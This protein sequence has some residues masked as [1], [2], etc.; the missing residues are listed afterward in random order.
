MSPSGKSPSRPEPSSTARGG[1][2]SAKSGIWIGLNQFS[3]DPRLHRRVGRHPMPPNPS[4]RQA[5]IPGGSARKAMGERRFPSSLPWRPSTGIPGRDESPRGRPLR[6]HRLQPA[7]P[8]VHPTVD[9]DHRTGVGGILIDSD[10]STQVI[11]EP[12]GEWF[13]LGP[14]CRQTGRCAWSGFRAS[15]RFRSCGEWSTDSHL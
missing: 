3:K 2:V 4:P 5:L 9:D 15:L 7:A 14:T 11:V 1:S 10:S 8:N 6:A 13:H 12:G